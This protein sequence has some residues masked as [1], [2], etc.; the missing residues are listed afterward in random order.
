MHFAVGWFGP[1]VVAA[2]L[3]FPQ[4]LRR[5]SGNRGVRYGSDS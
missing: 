5:S 3:S 4:Q 1:K 2:R